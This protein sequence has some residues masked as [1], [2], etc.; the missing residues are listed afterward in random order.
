MAEK[1]VFSISGMRCTACSGNVEKRLK[2]LE[3][4]ES[5]EVSFT[6]AEAVVTA[7]EK[8]VPD[9]LIISTVS[10][11]GFTA[12]RVAADAPEPEEKSENFFAK[13]E[14]ICAAVSTLLVF[15]ISMS[16]LLSGT[17]A[18]ICQALLASIV[19]YA[20]RAFYRRGIP[21]LFAGTPDMD[22]LISCGSGTAMLYSLYL[23]LRGESCHL[24]FDSAAMIVFLVMCGKALEERVR[25]N[26]IDAVRSLAKLVPD[27]AFLVRGDKITEVAA[28]TL[29]KGDILQVNGGNRIPADGRVVQESGWVDESMF[30][31]ETLA[32]EKVPGSSVTGGT[33]C[34]GGAF[35]M[36]V[37]RLGRDTVLANIISM[38]KAA[39]ATKA[40]VARLA[41]IAA[42]Y[43]TF[44][45]LTVSLLTLVIH[46]LCGSSF[47]L[48]VNFSLA[49]MVVSCPCALGLATPV[50]LIAGIGRGASSGI[51][52][53]SG[54]A[55]ERACKVKCAAFDKTGTVTS[56]VLT[57]EKIFLCGTVSE[58]K[59]LKALACAEQGTAH[60]LARAAV[61]AAEERNIKLTSQVSGLKNTPGRGISAVIDG[62]T[63][64]FGS[65]EFLE[66]CSIDTSNA[67]ETGKYSTIYSSCDGKFAGVAAFSSKLRPGAAGT[68]SSLKSMGI[69][70]VML[71]GDRREAVES[72]AQSVGMDE[73][74]A[75][76]MPEEKLAVAGK[77]KEKYLLAM[78]GDGVNDAPALAGAD[79]GI[80]IGSGSAS[81][82]DAA[83]I[84]IT[85]DDISQV[86]RAILLSRATMRVIKQNLF[87]AFCY[88]IIAIPVAAGAFYSFGIPALPPGICSA[89]MAV[90]SLTVIL[91]AARLKGIKL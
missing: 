84:V 14:F 58:E 81:A 72:V 32:V 23:T 8:S 64:L 73:F 71:S 56:G 42:G 25:R 19:I 35:R 36:Q 61:S 12:Q 78:V 82:C 20:G 33:L 52:I 91:N 17:A 29:C 13:A 79:I 89:L 53:K 90:S 86:S 2:K 5:C 60:P 40:P 63:W 15:E 24:Y 43:F 87:W 51:L 70:C 69:R 34:T 47:Y 41:D 66:S 18:A 28:S 22:T 83:G 88:N 67:P 3:G 6:S 26:T 49:V 30:T 1:R 85:G 65:R 45:V 59:L 37:E 4:V 57:L 80:A 27:T 62:E 31:G 55:L 39:Q 68:I 48:A 44:F 54:E 38:V 11:L 46:L 16:D 75:Q 76:L 9:E 50:A 7:D 77:L 74:H 21:A 10:K